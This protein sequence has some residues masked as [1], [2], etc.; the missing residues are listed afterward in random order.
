M[1]VAAQA[2]RAY[3]R[4]IAAEQTAKYMEQV[5]VAAEAGA[6]LGRRMAKAGNWSKLDQAREQS[7]YAEATAQLARA[8]QGAV[9]ERERL[10]RILGLGDI[11][12]QL[13]VPVMAAR[14]SVSASQKSRSASIN[15]LTAPT[16]SRASAS[17]SNTLTSMPL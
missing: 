3:F 7:F 15:A 9:S 2:R 16:C 6:E 11:H 17:N 13:E 5:N 1:D 4:T 8:R 12:A 14:R 10:V